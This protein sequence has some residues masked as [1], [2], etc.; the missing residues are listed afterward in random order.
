MSFS[1]D[2]DPNGRL[3]GPADLRQRI[4]QA[5]KAS[6]LSVEAERLRRPRDRASLSVLIQSHRMRMWEANAVY[7]TEY[8]T[9]VEVRMR[10]IMD[11]RGKKTLDHQHPQGM[12]DKFSASDIRRQAER[13][14]RHDHDKHIARLRRV[15]EH[16]LKVLMEKAQRKQTVQGKAKDGFVR[17]TDRR[18]GLERRAQKP[19]RSA[20][21]PSPS[22]KKTR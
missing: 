9:R 21:R 16:D 17:A 5:F 2:S 6:S 10:D 19:N 22:R 12:F 3:S 11:L 7:K 4:H 15:R 8:K 20:Q 1:D 13:D 18:A 14:V